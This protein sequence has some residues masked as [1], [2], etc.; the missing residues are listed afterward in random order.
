MKQGSVCLTESYIELV[1][2]GRTNSDVSK[3]RRVCLAVGRAP[4]HGA[5][6]VCDGQRRSRRR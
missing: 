1:A 2:T 4:E 5:V 6:E 3:E